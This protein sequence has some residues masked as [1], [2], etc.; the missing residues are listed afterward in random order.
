[1]EPRATEISTECSYRNCASVAA[2]IS[3][4]WTACCWRGGDCGR[5]VVL[6]VRTGT[7]FPLKNNPKFAQLRFHRQKCWLRIV[8]QSLTGVVGGRKIAQ[9]KRQRKR[10]D[11]NRGSS[12]VLSSAACA[13]PID[14]AEL[15]GIGMPFACLSL[16]RLGRL[17]LSKT[18]IRCNTRS[19][20]LPASRHTAER[21]AALLDIL[22]FVMDMWYRE[23]IE[24][25]SLGATGINTQS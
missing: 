17:S 22:R 7:I 24:T 23:A 25:S 18:W 8:I 11:A 13:L 1:M 20:V 12:F 15:V 9:E 6:D 10:N 14:S 16:F 5:K 4:G 19:S 3:C 21:A 2:H